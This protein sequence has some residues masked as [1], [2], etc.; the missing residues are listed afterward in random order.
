MIFGSRSDRDIPV[1]LNEDG[2][3]S[4][5]ITIQ[6]S[7]NLNLSTSVNFNVT[8]GTGNDTYYVDAIGDVV[9]ESID[10][11]IDTV[12]ASIDYSLGN[13]LEN[14]TLTGGSNLTAIGNDLDNIITGNTGNSTLIGGKGN[15]TL[16]GNRGADFL[17]GGIG[18]DT[19]EGRA[20]NDT[21]LVDNVGDVVIEL[22]NGGT[23]TVR[24]SIDYTLTANVENLILESTALVGNGN[25]LNNTITGNSLDNT[26]NGGDGNDTLI[27]NDGNDLL[28]G[29]A[30]NDNM[31][32]GNGNDTYYVDSTS[33]RVTE[34]VDAGIDTVIASIDYSIAGNNYANVE[35][36]TLVDN[37]IRATGNLLDNTLS[38]NAQN[39]I[40]DGREGAD[41]M[42][43]GLGDDSYYVDN[44][45]DVVTENAN[46]GL[47]LVNASIDY[48]LAAEVENLTLTGTANN[49]TGNELNNTITGNSR[50][51]QLSGLA[52]DDTL[53][54][55]G[56]NDILDGG[57][58]ND[59]MLGGGGNDTYFVD[60]LGDI[61]TEASNSGTDT[62]ESSINYTLTAN[63]ENLVL[64]VIALNGTGND[65]GNIITG[66]AGNNILTGGRGN[67]TLFGGAGVDSFVLNK[68][69]QGID[70]IKDFISGTDKIA[71]S[72]SE[73]G[74]GLTAGNPLLSSQIRLGA[75]VSS[76]NNSAQR[77]LFN[78][79]NGNLY[80]DA[81]GVG[82]VAAVKIAKLEGV[83]GLTSSDFQIGF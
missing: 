29:G 28:N 15:D 83:S 19:L 38:G 24:A 34:T 1:H 17:D 39:N 67:D 5:V 70:I 41:T 47:D 79:T 50:N 76:A 3:G 71:I 61:V 31:S 20:G 66:N 60:N 2:T 82:G 53:I 51:N 10:G 44:I 80:F 65:L 58:G 69:S 62:V 68:P 49:G 40:L 81:D 56:G 73:F 64:T 11:G 30:G 52:G 48:T 33:D 27:G 26:L 16:V 22:A 23:D 13:Y 12:N 59:T 55:S 78:T 35:N 9:N 45:G 57:T 21:Y 72:Q 6:R 14:L 8:G 54:G 18:V 25:A 77:F 75:G 63:I 7:G 36:I 32:G 43:G 4:N 42:I 74:G 37:A 46:G